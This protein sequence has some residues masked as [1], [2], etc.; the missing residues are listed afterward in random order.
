M[1]VLSRKSRYLVQ[2]LAQRFL[3][4]VPRIS[5]GPGKGLRF[6]AGPAAADFVAGDYEQPV[7]TAIIA[8]LREGDVFF[9]IGANVGYF[10][11][12]ASRFVGS[13]GA[14]YAFEPVPANASMVERNARLNEMANIRVLRVAASMQT[15]KSELMLARFSG[16]AILKNAGVPP[17]FAG[18]LSVETFSIDDLVKFRRIQPPDVVKIDVEGAELQVLHGM[19]D[20][21]RGWGPKTIIEV[22]DASE[23]RCMEK[24][25]DCR[26]YLQRLGYRVEVLRNSYKDGQWFV[27]HLVGIKE[28]YLP[29]SWEK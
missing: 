20:T 18:S 9:D 10:S 4:S 7:L 15:G 3:G 13:S 12:L 25:S 14:V 22:D 24:L 26:E 17:D 21:L 1:N 8:L 28:G 19:I 29:S 6:D 11:V 5:S 2:R 23:K 27:R 16:G